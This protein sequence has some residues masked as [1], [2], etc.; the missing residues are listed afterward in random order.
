VDVFKILYEGEV[1]EQVREKEYMT[2][3]QT[4]IPIVFSLYT[5][6]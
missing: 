3:K 6:G 2:S 1:E 4:G 5:G